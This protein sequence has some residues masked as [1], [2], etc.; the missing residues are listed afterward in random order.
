M[1]PIA[2]LPGRGCR[3]TSSGFSAEVGGAIPSD[4]ILPIAAN[5]HWMP[6]ASLVQVPFIMALG[7]TPFASAL[8]FALAGALAAPL[9]W[10]IGRDV[11]A[12]HAVSVGAGVLTAIPA[13]S[14][15]FMP[16]P[17]NFGLFQPLAVAA[18]W[19][20]ARGLRGDRR[21]FALGGLA[22]G[23]ATLSRTDGVLLAAVLGL[24]FVWDRVRR[25]EVAA[26]GCP[27]SASRRRPELSACSWCASFPGISGSSPSS[28]S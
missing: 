10:A 5:A 4:P 27:L 20:A 6:L 2:W 7:A 23:L 9:M 18:L 25:G 12:R 8:P 11:G 17:D 22:A 13:L 19:M 21:A 1:S 26:A 28:V 3:S 16:Q 15:V 14:V 24:V